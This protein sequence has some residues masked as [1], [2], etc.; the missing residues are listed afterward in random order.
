MTRQ[1]RQRAYAVQM[2]ALAEEHRVMKLS[3][4]ELTRRQKEIWEDCFG[5]E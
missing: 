5:S 4:E 2:A 3:R 1:A